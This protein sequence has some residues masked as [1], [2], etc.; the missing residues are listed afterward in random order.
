MKVRYRV[1]PK[2]NKKSSFYVNCHS[3]HVTIQAADSAFSTLLSLRDRLSAWYKEKNISFD[4]IPTNTDTACCFAWKVDTETG[5]GLDT[6]YYGGGC[7]AGEWIEAAEAQ[8][9]AEEA[10]NLAPRGKSFAGYDHEDDYAE[11]D[12]FAPFVEAVELGYFNN[13]PVVVS[14]PS[15]TAA[16]SSGND[17]VASVSS[18][19]KTSKGFAPKSATKSTAKGSEG[20][21]K[22]PRRAPKDVP[23]DEGMILGPK[24]EGVTSKIM[25]TLD[26]PSVIFEGVLVGL[27]KRDTKTGKSIVNGSIVDDTNS[28]KFI[29]FTNSPEEG[30]ALL[31]QLKGLQR[32][33]VQGSVNFDDRFDKDYILSIR[34]I[35]ALETTSVERT[36][37]RPDSRVELH[38]HTKMSDKDALVSVKDL[39]KTIKK[40]GH[41]AEPA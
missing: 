27:D 30:D 11:F 41:P 15:Q 1:V 2:Q 21:G 31:K 22:Y 13:S 20:D 6:Y 36:E 25:G 18:T 9:E 37:N 7:G 28:I 14:R 26:T 23:T 17:T 12:D 19:P 5:E 24:I 40:W 33:R 3:Q 16:A 10:K 39:F 34:S 8:R 29:K 32:V 4:D 38:L 35:E